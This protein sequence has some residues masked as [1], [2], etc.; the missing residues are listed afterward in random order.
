MSKAELDGTPFE[1]MK[2]K[3]IQV[4]YHNGVVVSGWVGVAKYGDA[5]AMED[6]NSLRGIQF[7][8]H[9]IKEITVLDQ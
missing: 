6:K 9:G 7:G 4:N 1:G 2:G 8:I 5:M 3:K